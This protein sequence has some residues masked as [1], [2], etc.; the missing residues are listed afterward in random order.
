MREAVA[1]AAYTRENE[2]GEDGAGFLEVR[3]ESIAFHF[4]FRFEPA[5]LSLKGC[6]LRVSTG[7]GRR[8]GE[9]RA[10]VIVR[11]LNA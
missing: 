2:E 5:D 11:F 9:T 3:L 8:S 6:C 10:S 7:T 1:R 4:D